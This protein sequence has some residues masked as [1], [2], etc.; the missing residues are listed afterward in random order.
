[1]TFAMTLVQRVPPL[2]FRPGAS[3]SINHFNL[4]PRIEYRMSGLRASDMQ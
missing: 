2:L 4:L 3:K 1:M